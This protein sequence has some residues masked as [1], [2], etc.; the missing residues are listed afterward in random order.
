MFNKKL[1]GLHDC[2]FKN[3]MSAKAGESTIKTAEFCLERLYFAQ[4]IFTI[5]IA[6][7]FMFNGV[8]VSSI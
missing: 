4:H 7:L 5:Y 3:T 1:L 6:K 2:H 8:S